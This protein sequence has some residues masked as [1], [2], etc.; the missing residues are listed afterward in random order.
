MFLLKQLLNPIFPR[1]L[2][3]KIGHM[4]K[5]VNFGERLREVRKAK[6]WT[7]GELAELVE[8]TQPTV[9]GWEGMKHF[10]TFRQTKVCLIQLVKFGIDP[11]YFWD[12]DV[13]AWEIEPEQL[14]QGC[15]LLMRLAVE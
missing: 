1:N 6:G 11:A 2:P 13:D 4:N 3:A 5:G 8:R 7:Q 14:G 10:A 12:A 15:R 9:A